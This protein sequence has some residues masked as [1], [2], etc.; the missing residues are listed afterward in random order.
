[1]SLAS[2]LLYALSPNPFH[3]VPVKYLVRTQDG[4]LL[5]PGPSNQEFFKWIFVRKWQFLK[6]KK[7]LFADIE[8]Q[9]VIADRVF[10]YEATETALKPKAANSHLN[11]YFPNTGDTQ[12][13]LSRAIQKNIPNSGT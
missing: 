6:W 3:F 9:Y 13:N 11:S 7:V 10:V 2:K 1:M 8:A 12:V 5:F 4:K